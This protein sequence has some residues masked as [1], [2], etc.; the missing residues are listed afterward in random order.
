MTEQPSRAERRKQRLRA[1]IIEEATKLYYQNGGE[2]GG[3][4]N[5]TLESIADRSD[6]SLRTFFR[7][8]ESKQDVIYL[9][10]RMSVAD[11]Q[12]HVQPLLG[13]MP[14]EI[15]AMR[16]GISQ[17]V[18]FIEMPVNRDRLVR[19]LTSP[20]FADRRAVWRTM[21]QDRLKT[22]VRP[23]IEDHPL[24]DAEAGA[25]SF[26]VRS[27]IDLGLERWLADATRDPAPLVMEALEQIR[28]SAAKFAA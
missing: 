3:F 19:S 11:L 27:A 14:P 23:F 16:G 13:K 15:A 1:R 20:N 7:Y 22:L 5:T 4:E 2:D 17:L 25:I 28:R 10:C 21:T 24:A 12:L 9:D 6:I 26:I 18:T 8:F